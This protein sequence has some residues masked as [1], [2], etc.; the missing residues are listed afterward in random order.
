VEFLQKSLV[1]GISNLLLSIDSD[2]KDRPDT[3][4]TLINQFKSTGA[5]IALAKETLG[6]KPKIELEEG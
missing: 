3:I 1:L 4:H 5:D 2:E 6:W